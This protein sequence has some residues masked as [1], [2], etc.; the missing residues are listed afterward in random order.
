LCIREAQGS[1]RRLLVNIGV[2]RA[3]ESKKQAQE[4][5]RTAIDSDPPIELCR[6]LMTGGSWAKAM[7]ILDKMEN[8]SPESVRIQVVQYLSKVAR[9]SKTEKQA[10]ATLAILENFSDG[11]Y[12]PSDG[13]AP[14]VLAV[15]RVML[16]D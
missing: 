5:L 2:C 6:F 16:G 15:G 12:N 8:M 3:A 14:L 10:G 9:T 1:P 4:L 13:V 7:G 11:P